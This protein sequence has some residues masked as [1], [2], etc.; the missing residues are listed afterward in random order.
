MAWIKRNL[1]FLVGSAVALVLIGLAGWYL[2]AKWQLNGENLAKLEQDYAMLKDLNDKKPHPGNGKIDN[3]K[4]AI[5]QTA[6]LGGFKDKA[7]GRFAR[8]APIPDLPKAD[9]TD[10]SFATNFSRTIS[11]LQRD[12][13]N[14]SITVPADY[15]FSF[16][17]QARKLSFA[18][19]SLQT[20]SVQ[21]GEVRALCDVLFQAKINAIESI[22]RE[23]ASP[24]D[25]TSSETG[26]YLPD[27]SQT[28]ASVG[29]VLSPYELTF[30]CFS[31]ELG[32]AVAGFA[33]SPYSMVV[34]AI[35]VEALAPG[36]PEVGP[37]FAQ[38]INPGPVSI[39]PGMPE[40]PRRSPEQ[41]ARMRYL[42]YGPSAFGRGGG[43]GGAGGYGPGR[44]S[45]DRPAPGTQPYRPPIAPA[46]GATT[47]T[48]GA[49]AGPTLALDEKQ[50]K[51]VMLVSIV[52]LEAKPA[53]AGPAKPK[54][55]PK[56]VAA[57]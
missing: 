46:P 23:R 51:V 56:P 33:C 18:A 14:A 40:A 17:A 5:E 7:R 10:Q 6:E 15:S 12:A 22:R 13:T 45:R 24:D 50:L 2:Y 25:L 37:T 55:G 21:L 39:A 20:L 26:D 57:K 34:K 3:I 30:R 44:L 48:P 1:Y 9:L 53:A 29:A 19:G 36:T 41:E 35:N 54:P 28:N 43:P 42:R 47:G 16:Q 27:K 52:K 49:K 31:Q 32:T 38:P 8:I 4:T 11:Q